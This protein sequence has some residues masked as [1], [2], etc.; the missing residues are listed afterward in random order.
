MGSVGSN[1]AVDVNGVAETIET[2]QGR[3]VRTMM[4]DGFTSAEASRD[5]F[6]ILQSIVDGSVSPEMAEAYGVTKQEFEKIIT[7]SAILAMRRYLSGKDL[8]RNGLVAVR[9]ASNV[10]RN[11]FGS[12]DSYGKAGIRARLEEMEKRYKELQ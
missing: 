11:M 5:A 6:S 4:D 2:M 9:L 3:I 10:E 7:G 12:F 1:S 8:N